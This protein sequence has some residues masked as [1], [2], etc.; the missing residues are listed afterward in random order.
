MATG[1]IIAHFDPKGERSSNWRL[2][3]QTIRPFVSAGVVVSTGISERDSQVAREFGF[4][5]IRRKNVGYD[6]MSYAV[7]YDAMKGIPSLEQILFCNDS[8]FISRPEIF[9]KTIEKLL[10]SKDEATF[11]TVSNQIIRHGQSYLF[12]LHRRVF[13]RREFSDFLHSIRPL[14]TRLQVIF[15]YE[16]G[17]SHKLDDL[18]VRFSGLIETGAK[19]LFSN[20]RGVNP[21]HDHAAQIDDELGIVK[22][23]RLVKNP[24]VLKDNRRLQDLARQVQDTQPQS[25]MLVDHSRPKAVIVCHCHYIEVV[26]ELLDYFDR[27]PD[28]VEIHVTSSNSDVLTKFKV[29][30]RRRH[31]LLGV[32]ATENRGRDVRPFFQLLSMLDIDDDIPILKIHGKRSLYSPKGESWRKDMLT[33]LAANEPSIEE[34]LSQFEMNPRL[35]MIGPD[36]SFVGNPQYWGAN[37]ERVSSLME[38]AGNPSNNSGDLGFFAGTMFWIR[39]QCA[40]QIQQIVDHDA[41]ENEDGQRDGTYGHALERAIPMILSKKG[42]ELREVSNSSPLHPD[43]VREKT[44]EYF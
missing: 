11:A 10:D 22:Y 16:L 43:L 34:I 19:R 1:A 32:I 21:T 36:N 9:T 2:L 24:L 37:K 20:K 15:T 29:K 28:G 31:I 42:W 12:S 6:F 40:K 17:F 5:V 33:S 27:F 26:D 7:G 14:A 8:F 18:R 39:S 38:K 4:A 3:L 41:F 13:E 44:L 30:W 25:R 23:E 35:G